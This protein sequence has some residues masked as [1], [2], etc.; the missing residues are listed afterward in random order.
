VRKATSTAIAEASGGCAMAAAAEATRPQSLDRQQV[1]ATTLFD[2]EPQ[3]ISTEAH[4]NPRRIPYRWP[5]YN[6]E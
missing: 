6:K 3:K 1:A 4:K 5:R 2:G